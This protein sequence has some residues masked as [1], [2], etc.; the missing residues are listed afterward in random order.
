MV[1]LAVCFLFSN[2]SS[3]KI[4]HFSTPN[5]KKEEHKMSGYL[6]NVAVGQKRSAIHQDC[7]ATRRLGFRQRRF[8]TPTLSHLT[9]LAWLR[10]LGHASCLLT[11]FPNF[12]MG[13]KLQKITNEDNDLPHPNGGPPYH[14]CTYLANHLPKFYAL[15]DLN[16]IIII[17]LNIK[18]LIK[19]Y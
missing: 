7:V 14:Q 17:F 2:W 18:C 13:N 6:W 19:R 15:Y 4:P 16:I 1:I 5:H 3:C 10:G 12:E 9:W 8:L 11:A